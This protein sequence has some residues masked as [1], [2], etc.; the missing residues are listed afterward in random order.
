M[1]HPAIRRRLR[2]C[3]RGYAVQA[4]GAPTLQVFNRHIK[5]LQKERSA[6]DVDTGRKVDYLKDEVAIRLCERLLVRPLSSLVAITHL[7]TKRRLNRT[8]TAN[9]HWSLTLELIPAT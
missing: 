5:Y 2:C 1:P 7:L 6:L 9:F 8:S 3:T 4:P